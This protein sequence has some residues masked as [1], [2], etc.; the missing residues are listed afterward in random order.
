MAQRRISDLNASVWGFVAFTG[1]SF[2]AGG[3]LVKKLTNDGIDAFTVTWVPFLFG[4]LI[5]LIHGMITKGLRWSSVPAGILLGLSSS[6][7]PSLIFNLGFDRLPAGINTLLISLGPIFT[8][9]V[10]HFVFAD[11]R[12][13]LLK[14]LGLVAAYGGVTILAAGSIDDGGN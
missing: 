8:A 3:L 9:I 13:N 12:F 1:I 6:L 2:G 10:A 14:A 7:G 11:E 5:A 4:G